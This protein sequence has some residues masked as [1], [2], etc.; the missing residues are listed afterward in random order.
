[1]RTIRSAGA[2]VGAALYADSLGPRGSPSA[3]YLG[4]LW[5]NTRA[6]MDGFTDGSLPR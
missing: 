5:G 1:M 3:T 6:L 4:S 2:K